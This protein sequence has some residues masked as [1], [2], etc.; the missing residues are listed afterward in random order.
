MAARTRVLTHAD[1]RTL[2]VVRAKT[3]IIAYSE[4]ATPTR[5]DIRQTHASEDEAIRAEAALVASWSA[6]GYA[7]SDLLP[8]AEGEDV[9]FAAPS[10]D[11]LDAIATDRREVSSA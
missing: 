10:F 8:E 11:F 1:G 7:A 4:R 6:K 5:P 2:T 3:I 9:H